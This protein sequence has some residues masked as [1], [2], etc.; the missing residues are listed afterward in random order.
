MRNSY[1][2]ERYQ[3]QAYG[4]LI[5]N[6]AFEKIYKTYRGR[7]SLSGDHPVIQSFGFLSDAMIGLFLKAKN[8]WM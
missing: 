2:Y 5:R 4:S 8:K 6:W 7:F 3:R 1:L